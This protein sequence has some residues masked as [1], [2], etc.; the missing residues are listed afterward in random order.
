MGEAYVAIRDDSGIRSLSTNEQD[1]LRS[2]ANSSTILRVDGRR[3]N[4]HRKVKLHLGRWDNGAECTV[5]WGGGTRVTSLCTADLVPPSPD[6]PNE[7]MI[8]FMVELSPMAGSSYRQAPAISNGPSLN[9]TSRGPNYA[10]QKQRLFTNRI[11]RSV[12]RIVLMGGALDTEALVL[13]P[14]KWVWRLT[15]SLTVLDD[16]G[17]VLDASIMA[18]IAALRHYRKPQVDFADDNNTESADTVLLPSMIPSIVKEA[19]PLP[20]HHTPLSASFALIPTDG[21]TSST[22]NS[23]SIVTALIDPTDREELVQFGNL[24]M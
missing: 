16:G 3:G 17:N 1:F 18:A 2:C 13:A 5:Q 23:T 14:G 22:S 4:E 10:D 21:V 9:S 12:E 15:V 11:L 20:L 24:T 19:T 6:R 8:N 7:G